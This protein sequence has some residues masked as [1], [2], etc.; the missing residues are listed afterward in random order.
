[1]DFGAL[2]LELGVW[3]LAFGALRAPRGFSFL[4]SGFSF[5]VS[6]FRK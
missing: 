5:L 4:V 6:R 2:R 1:V 3:S